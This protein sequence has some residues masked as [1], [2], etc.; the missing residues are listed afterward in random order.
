MIKRSKGPASKLFLDYYRDIDLKE[1][2]S[3]EHHVSGMNPKLGFDAS[4]NVLS[5]QEIVSPPHVV[6][7]R[8]TISTDSEK[9][10]TGTHTADPNT[11][12]GI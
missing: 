9:A 3:A 5:K 12:Q 1:G 7:A 11:D 2:P 10:V 8:K 4:S 6:E